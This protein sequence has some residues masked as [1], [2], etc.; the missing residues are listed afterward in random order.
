MKRVLRYFFIDHFFATLW[1]AIAIAGFF[2]LAQIIRDFTERP[3]QV[4]FRANAASEL[5]SLQ[6]TGSANLVRPP[7]PARN[8][9]SDAQ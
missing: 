3:I 6:T 8:E 1:S 2:F 7:A 4:V 5:F 9:A